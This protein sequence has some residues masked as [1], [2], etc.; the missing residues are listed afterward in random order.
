MKAHNLFVQIVSILYS[1]TLM[2]YLPKRTDEMTD[3]EWVYKLET[4][5]DIRIKEA[6]PK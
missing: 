3:Y 2:E 4:L 1:D 6:N 5:L